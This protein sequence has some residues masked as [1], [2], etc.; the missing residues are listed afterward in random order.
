VELA[1]APAMRIPMAMLALVAACGPNERDNGPGGVDA[2]GSDAVDAPLEP[3]LGAIYAHSYQRLYKVDPDTLAVTLVGSFR[4]PSGYENELMTDIAVDKDE[5]IT[6]ISFGAVFSVNKLTAEVTLRSNLSGEQFNGLTFLP[7]ANGDEILVGTGLGG[8]LWQIDPTGTN[9]SVQI[10]AYGGQMISSGDLVSVAGF[11]T[12]ATV[13]NGS[14]ADYLAR[15]DEA[16]G[17]GSVIGATGFTDIW[18]IGF[19]RNKVFGFV[20]T[21]Q[22]VLI[23]VTSGQATY[24]STGPEN[25]AGAGV[26]TRAPTT[27]L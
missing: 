13:K 8:T 16:T 5:N 6:G 22:F 10:G 23:D 18:G 9:P 12:V 19:W 25:W 27:P 15:I 7:Q 24:I 14:E 21:N 26:T 3:F 11:G 20:A 4:W 1:Y 2:P 17:A